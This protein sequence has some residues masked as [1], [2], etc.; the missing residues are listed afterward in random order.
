MEAWSKDREEDAQET[1]AESE[2]E[3]E[4]TAVEPKGRG[5]KTAA[6]K[7]SKVPPKKGASPKDKAAPAGGKR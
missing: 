7:V 2:K 6:K 4:E 5:K 3:A 1:A